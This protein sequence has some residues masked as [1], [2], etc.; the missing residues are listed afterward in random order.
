MQ[1]TPPH[2]TQ[3]LLEEM[4]HFRERVVRQVANGPVAAAAALLD[5]EPQP[6]HIPASPLRARLA[7]TMARNSWMQSMYESFTPWGVQERRGREQDIQRQNDHRAARERAE[8]EA[9]FEAKRAMRPSGEELDF[10]LQSDLEIAGRMFGAGYFSSPLI[11]EAIAAHGDAGPAAFVD[12]GGNVKVQ[13]VGDRLG[14]YFNQTPTGDALIGHAQQWAAG[15]VPQNHVE[16]VFLRW[17]VLFHEMAHCEYRQHQAPFVPS[18]GDIPV[19]AREKMNDWVYGEL[20]MVPRGAS[21]MLEENYVDTYAAMALLEATDHDPRAVKVLEDFALRRESARKMGEEALLSQD[22]SRQPDGR[23]PVVHNTDFSLRRVLASADSWRGRPPHELK[24]LATQ[25]ASDGLVD[26]MDPS[27]VMEMPDGSSQ[28]IGNAVRAH[29]LP[30]TYDPTSY[31]DLLTRMAESHSRGGDI[32]KWLEQLPS[33]H[34]AT[35]MLRES[36]GQLQPSLD[37]LLESPIP[38]GYSGPH[39]SIRQGMEK[40][41]REDYGAIKAVH[42]LVD[43]AP[44]PVNDLEHPLHAKVRESYQKERAFIMQSMSPSATPQA[45]PSVLESPTSVVCASLGQW[46]KAR[47]KPPAGLSPVQVGARKAVPS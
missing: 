6:T 34:P 17:L 5:S 10:L 4:V 13:M 37:A 26:F 9:R 28:S 20:G 12:P 29:L 8:W 15:N 42:D 43:A 7:K 33:S 3:D 25:I 14:D 40:I 18:H 30:E 2:L 23:F 19:D 45:A 47:E 32:G 1:T 38:D 21:V 22:P 24:N 44:V 46:R 31:R 35:G 39:A 27:R 41:R 11:I 16:Q 36:W